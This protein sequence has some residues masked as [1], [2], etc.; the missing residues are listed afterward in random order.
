MIDWD[1]DT[2]YIYDGSAFQDM[3]DKVADEMFMF[4]DPHFVK[5]DW[6]PTNL[7]PCK[8]G[9]W[10]SRMLVEPFL[11]MLPVVCHFKRLMHR[12]WEYFEM[13]LAYTMTMFDIL[14]QWH[15][16]H[17][18]DDGLVRLSIAEVSL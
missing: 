12:V 11:F 2:G 3:V 8:R 13:C 6:H 4:R 14:V 9:E 5:K 17:P 15:G 18:D 7:K 10:N 1:C 16:L